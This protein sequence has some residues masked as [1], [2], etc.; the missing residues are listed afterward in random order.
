MTGFDRTGLKSTYL[1]VLAEHEVERIHKGALQ[2]LAQT[3]IVIHDE[4]VLS[5]LDEAGCWVNREDRRVRILGQVIEEALARAPS[6]TTLYN[7]QGELAMALGA[8]PLHA[9]TSSGATGI[10]DLNSGQRREPTRQDAAHAVRVADVL[11]HV[12]GVSTMAVQPA[13]VPA[14]MVK[15]VRAAMGGAIKPLA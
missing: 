13:D 1:C 5:L 6:V 11:R 4:S 9:R 12:H 2:V 3:G 8:G 14:G 7:R 15:M 10:L